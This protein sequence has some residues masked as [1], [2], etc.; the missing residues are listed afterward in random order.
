MLDTYPIL[1]LLP[2]FVAI[3]LVITTKKVLPSL[4]AGILVAGLLIAD[5]NPLTMIVSVWEAVLRLVWDEGA[6]NWYTIL[7]VAFLF[8]LGI[9]TA[10]VM[11]SGGASAFTEWAAK[12]IKTRRGAQVLTGLLGMLIFIDDYF[13]AL[14]VG[15]VARPITDRSEE[16]TSELQSRGHLVC[17][18]LLEK[19]KNAT[20]NHT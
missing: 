11:M 15:Q 4:G 12:R 18:L 3:V 6:I 17:R 2:P 14:A 7:I 13:N 20:Q 1:T 19:K 5:L 10:L 8:Q 9:I 16:H